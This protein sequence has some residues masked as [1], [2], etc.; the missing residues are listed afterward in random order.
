MPNNRP[1]G[2]GPIQPKQLIDAARRDLHR[3]SVNS[4]RKPV[5]V[6]DFDFIFKEIYGVKHMCSRLLSKKKGVA[7][8]VIDKINV[9]SLLR[10]LLDEETVYILRQMALLCHEVR[11]NGGLTSKEIK[12]NEKT[13]RTSCDR[14]RNNFGIKK[15]KSDDDIDMKALN[16]F[17]ERYSDDDDYYDSDDYGY[18]DDDDYGYGYDSRSSND[19]ISELFGSRGGKRPESNSALAAVYN[20]AAKKRPSRRDDDYDDEDSWRNYSDGEEEDDDEE[21]EDE[22]EALADILKTIYKK[23]DNVEKRQDRMEK[24]HSIN[25]LYPLPVETPIPTPV[26]VSPTQTDPGLMASLDAIKKLT[27]KNG[28]DISKIASTLKTVATRVWELDDVVGRLNG[29]CGEIYKDFYEPTHKDETESDASDD[30]ISNEEIANILGATDDASNVSPI[31]V[32]DLPDV[33]AENS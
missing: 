31:S 11:G 10:M 29:F 25:D 3:L 19:I 33:G 13:V 5:Y 4:K 32:K 24:K 7:S 6:D 26:Q 9:E 1:D 20:K 15:I 22:D 16:R 27:T 18:Y 14:I 8:K 2:Q 23:I 28:S 21:Y 30:S 12:K 17:N